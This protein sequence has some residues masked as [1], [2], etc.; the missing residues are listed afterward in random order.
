[1]KI[2]IDEGRNCLDLDEQIAGDLGDWVSWKVPDELREAGFLLMLEGVNTDASG[3][4]GKQTLLV[5]AEIMDDFTR[6][7][8]TEDGLSGFHYCINGFHFK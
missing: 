5:S 4:H 3:T 6:V 7:V 8:Q 2:T 1:M